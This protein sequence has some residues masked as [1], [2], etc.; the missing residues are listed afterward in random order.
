MAV[1]EVSVIKF[2]AGDFLPRRAHE[3][4]AGIDLPV[5]EDVTIPVGAHRVVH[6]GVRV[7]VPTGHVGLVFVRSSV[8]I[9]RHLGLSN[10]VGVID[11]GYTGEIMVSLHNTGDVSQL[12]LAG[13]F[14][15]Q[16]VVMPISVA[17]L[18]RVDSLG[19]SERGEGGVG[20]TGR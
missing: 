7:A 17:P 5:A 19:S 2:V 10:G 18:L 8:G 4:D 13:D 1:G 12:L 15:A 20:S 16:L 6:T 9:K 14:V 11:S 3:D